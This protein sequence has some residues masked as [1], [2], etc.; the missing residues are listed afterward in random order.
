[1]KWKIIGQIIQDNV[2]VQCGVDK[3]DDIFLAGQ[4]FIADGLSLVPVDKKQPVKEWI[5]KI[6]L[7]HFPVIFIS[8]DIDADIRYVR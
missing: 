4:A 5:I 7:P 8:R 6:V 2:G 3:E 1:M